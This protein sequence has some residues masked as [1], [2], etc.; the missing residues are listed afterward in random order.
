MTN[1]TQE[2]NSCTTLDIRPEEPGRKLQHNKEIDLKVK[3]GS[4]S[5]HTICGILQM[6]D[7]L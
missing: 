5:S 3:D 4:K 7:N 1:P 2:Q 6:T